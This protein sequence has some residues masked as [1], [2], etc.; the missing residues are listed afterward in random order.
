MAAGSLLSR[1]LGLIRNMLAVALLGA[2]TRQSDI[3]AMGITIP[4]SIF[5]LVAGGALNTVLVPQIVRAIKND[6]DQGE[7][8][9]NRIITLVGLVI[10]LT[11]VL[12]TVA[13]PWL[14][15]VY[16]DNKWRAPELAAHYHGLVMLA[17]LTMP[18][19]FIFGVF[20]ITGQVLNARD[21]FGPMMWAPVA[22]NVVQIL[23]LLL[24]L[25]VWGTGGNTSAPFT[26]PQI[27]VL[28]IGSTLACLAQTAFMLL[29][30]RK[31]GIHYRPRFD[32]K[33]TGLRHT[34]DVAK[35]VLLSVVVGQ[36]V[37]I[38][39]TRLASPAT[40]AGH[41]AGVTTMQNATLMWM[42]PHGM[43][44]VSVT[45]AM[46]PA[47][48][49]LAADNHLR[50]V[51]KETERALKLVTTLIVPIAIGMAVVS[52]SV[53]MVLFGWGSGRG[54]VTA[55][56]WTLFIYCFALPLYT[57]FYVQIRTFYALEDTRS[58][59][60]LNTITSLSWLGMAVVGTQLLVHLGPDSASSWVAPVLAGTFVLAHLIG[61][62]LSFRRL[63]ERVPINV[64]AIVRHVVRLA[65]ATV[66]SA[67][68][69]FLVVRFVAGHHR[70]PLMHLVALLPAFAVALVL[71]VLCARAMHLDEVNDMARLLLRRG[72]TDG[73]S[74]PTPSRRL[75]AMDPRE[76]AADLV[77]LPEPVEAP[78]T[79]ATG[80]VAMPE[81][82]PFDD[83]CVDTVDEHGPVSQV[84]PG[85]ILGNRYRLERQII[86]RDSVLT[87][88][89][90]DQ[91]LSRPVLVHILAPHDSR[92]DEMLAAAR[93]AAIATDSRFLRVLDAV[94]STDDVLGSWIVC[95]FAPGV[96]VEALLQTGPLTAVEAGWVAREV[97]DA[98]IA[99]H[100]QGLHHLR[101]NPD[102]VVV[103]ET[104]NVKIVG[105]LTEAVLDP[106]ESELDLDEAGREARDVESIGNLL[107]AMLVGRWPEGDRYGLPAAPRDG[108][109][110]LTPR[111]VKAGI[112]PSLD[113]VCDRVLLSPPRCGLP[114]LRSA[115]DVMLEL[116]RILGSADGASALERRVQHPATVAITH[117]STPTSGASVPSAPRAYTP[118]IAIS[119]GASS[120]AEPKV[121]VPVT[122]NASRA[123][124]HEE[125]EPSSYEHLFRT[126]DD[127]TPAPRRALL[128]EAGPAAAESHP[129]AEPDERPVPFTPVP[130]P[131]NPRRVRASVPDPHDRSAVKHADGSPSAEAVSRS[132][133]WFLISLIAIALALGVGIAVTK[134]HPGAR[135]PLVPQPSVVS[136]SSPPPPATTKLPIISARDYDP[137]GSGREM[138]AR[139]R[140][141]VDGNPATAWT[142]EVYKNPTYSG[143]KS[144]VGLYVDLGAV[145]VVKRVTI[146]WREPGASF[147]IMVPKGAA[148]KAPASIVSWTDVAT[149]SVADAT[150]DIA[151]AAPVKTRYILV[152]ITS[153]PKT[154]HGF[155][156]GVSE[157]EVF[158]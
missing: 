135:T 80:V 116:S 22:N 51:R 156:A 88:E 37:Q 101:L 1:V 133:R 41:G 158:G 118:T 134:L 124:K 131:A 147:Q 142:T 7:S 19:I 60:T 145:K 117:A 111:Q 57:I 43:I 78:V 2:T 70:T 92:A 49:R 137:L 39:I 105:F 11:A 36:L 15:W 68:A 108:G 154:N 155:Q 61:V 23:N 59:F 141:A 127:G 149:N 121:T 34:A 63:A 4:T 93:R 109:T 14:L 86:R 25:V 47:I 138:P 30:M 87:W 152:W 148:T 8:Y 83:E 125:S 151:L 123:I 136:A 45:T 119:H 72:R 71:F 74:A 94:Y 27:L 24:Y 31:A 5:Y 84:H 62:V 77:A 55:L 157:I 143:K 153:V 46:I 3:F 122:A 10:G 64:P 110:L 13:A 12:C 95:E 99:M 40:T 98:L 146:T 96:S 115:N 132:W 17:Y 35:W 82:E 9:I 90:S 106:V 50:G 21:Q 114:P 67:V 26:T 89:A 73:R 107:Y 52:Y 65:V 18:Q 48:S 33:G 144:G 66:P 53:A 54:G 29:Y 126:E 85:E 130:A 58:T 91:V 112:S 69:A 42:L 129:E 139:V 103:S 120:A 16:A 79:A 113:Q 150:S 38:V 81:P 28:G 56:G 20:F 100:A 32:F 75:D 97:A 104:G 140:R 102:T 128:P 44:T 6:H 76:D